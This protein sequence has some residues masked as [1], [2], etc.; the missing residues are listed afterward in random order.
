M[1]FQWNTYYEIK[2]VQFG[3]YVNLYGNHSGST[4]PSGNVISLWSR[5]GNMDQKWKGMPYANAAKIVPQRNTGFVMNRHSRNNSAIAWPASTASLSDTEI[6][7]ITVNASQNLYRLKL[8]RRNLY[9]TATGASSTLYWRAANGSNTQ[10]FQLVSGGGSSTNKLSLP[11][12]RYDYIARGYTNSHRGIDYTVGN[13]TPILAAA[14]GTVIFTRTYNQNNQSLPNTS[15]NTM[16]NCMYVQHPGFG[17]TLYMHMNAPP[18][19]AVGTT[20]TRGQTIG[21]VGNTGNSTGNH[22]H[23]GFKTGSSFRY[24]D[25]NAY[26]DGTWVNPANY[27]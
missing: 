8:S 2:N 26:H 6:D 17:M 15:W 9:L 3:T 20:V 12:Q 14:D 16:G 13:G 5:T 19:L 10:L 7:F 27:M 4:I 25:V 11:V 24:N 21:Y 18:S 23:F 1:A 22:L